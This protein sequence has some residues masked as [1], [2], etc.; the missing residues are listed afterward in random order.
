[1]NRRRRA[2]PPLAVALSAVLLAAGALVLGLA[3]TAGAAGT[4]RAGLPQD[5]P[6]LPH[7]TTTLGAAPS[8]QTMNLD[9]SL[10]G[11]DPAGLAQA[12]AAVSTPGSPSYRDYLTPDEFAARFGPSPS[13]IAQ[14]S[15]T[16]RSEGLTVG[17]PLAGSSLL[18]VSG[19]VASVES[20]FGTSIESVQAPGTSRALVNTTAPTVPASLSGAVTG[21]LGLDGLSRERDMLKVHTGAGASAPVAAAN[22]PGAPASGGAA[23]SRVEGPH[24]GTPQACGSAAAATSDFSG[25][26][27]S[28]TMANLFGLSDLFGAGRTGLG[29]TIGIV[30]F[31]PYLSSDYS[32][33]Q[34]CY[35]LSNSIRN[36]SIDGG[37]GTGAGEGE[38]ALDVEIAGFNAPSAALVVY[39]APNGNDAES[40]D[41]FQRI[42]SDDA[43]Q[44]VTTSW[45]NCEAT[46]SGS[47]LAAENTTFSQMTMQGQTMIAASG[48]AGSEDCFPNGPSNTQLAVDDP[49][50]QPNVVSVGGTSMTSASAGSQVVWNDCKA[51]TAPTCAD[52]IF[53]GQSLGATGG[54]Y[55]SVW[56]RNPG[57]P[58]E[59]GGGTNP[60]GNGSSTGCRSVPDLSFPADPGEGGTVAIYN[61]R[62]YGFGGTSIDAPMTAGL[63]SDTNQ[64]C[65]R[66]VGR[67]GP[68]LYESTTGAD[69]TDVT[70]G[71]NDFTDT[72]GGLFTAG[73]G[74]DAATG[75]GTPVDQNLSLAL[76]GAGGCPTVTA[77]SP[78]TGPVTGAGAITVLGA[79]LASATT[80]SFGA[81]GTGTILSKSAGSITVVPPHA[82]K[83]TCVDVTVTNP[84]GTSAGSPADHYGFGGDLS[85]GQGYRF[86]ASDGGVFTYGSASFWGST[87][88]MHLNAPVVGLAG[89][90]S[91]NGYWLVASDGGIFSYGDAGFHGSMGGQRLNKPIVGITAT[92]DGGGYWEV[93]SDGGIFAFGDAGFYGSMGG[94]PLNRPIVGIAATPDGRG[95]WMVA[96]DGGI[97]SFGDAGFYGSMGGKPLN[98]PIVGIATAPNGAGYWMVAS[99]G[100]IFDFG[101]AGFD[102]SAGSIVLNEP[103]V[104]MAATPDGGGYWL[105]ASDGGIFSYGDAQFYGST[106]SIRLN[107]PIVGMSAT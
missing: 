3:G 102:G 62:W 67:V 64:G 25:T 80:V 83:P 22:P 36:V 24:A 68:A 93:A 26:Y 29:Q 13:E 45:G 104:G 70:G 97:F 63:L 39:Q 100:G 44:V 43:A 69:Y 40:L 73:T 34:S 58:T 6:A 4:P 53:S 81:E 5:V 60:C 54:G 41:L 48:D 85:C 33:F 10:A 92:P 7:G 65:N 11:Q 35:G 47:E 12:V 37:P 19:T 18:P 2:G 1:M 99:D 71:Q 8:G 74:Y 32:A 30:E 82:S 78:D 107:A 27:T 21:V 20:A 51:R 75:L 14:V 46:L 9:V 31:E 38:A 103:V 49:G 101:S 96:S 59:T 17:R 79:G 98:K 66:P 90:P 88:S 57:Q 89:T 23:E 76:Q 91:T 94:R 55:S 50:T 105:V 106:G 77:V 28:T 42:A 87:G 95:Y 52:K 72:N 16:L 84:L 15:S 56:P 61:G 86:V